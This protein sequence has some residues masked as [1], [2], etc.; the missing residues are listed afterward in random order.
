MSHALKISL[1]VA[2]ALLAGSAYASYRTQRR[3]ERAGRYLQ[4]QRELTDPNTLGNLGGTAF[5]PRY[6]DALKAEGYKGISVLQQVEATRI[7]KLIR[8]AFGFWNDDEEKI[9][10]A[11]DKIATNVQVSQVAKAYGP[12][13]DLSLLGRLK[14][15]LSETDFGTIKKKLAAKRNHDGKKGGTGP[16]TK[17]DA[18]SADGFDPEFYKRMR[19]EHKNLATPSKKTIDLAVSRIHGAWSIWGDDEDEVY[20]TLTDLPDKYAV[21]MV[22]KAYQRHGITLKKDMQERMSSSEFAEAKAIVDAKQPYTK[23]T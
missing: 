10:G 23:R 20:A 19:R 22:A 11:F 13:D 21:S 4:A 14:E 2:G 12:L 3:D 1:G 8:N 9:I 18:H 16:V 15:D 17:V 5:N 6:L 7:A